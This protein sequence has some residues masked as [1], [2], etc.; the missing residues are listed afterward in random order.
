MNFSFLIISQ[1]YYLFL[2]ERPLAY[3]AIIMPIT[4]Q[5]KAIIPKTINNIIST[6]FYLKKQTWITSI[7]EKCL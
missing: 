1:K 5:E 4:P 2:S 6:P 7:P 3:T